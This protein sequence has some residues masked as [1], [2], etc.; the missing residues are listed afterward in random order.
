[1][2]NSISKCDDLINKVVYNIS[3][4]IIGKELEVKNILKGMLAG[5]HVLIEDVPGT[6]KTTLV[7]AIAKSLNLSFSRIQFTPD[8]LPSD[9]TGVSIYNP[10]SMEFEFRKGPVFSN[11]VLADEINRTSPKTQSSLLEVMQERQVTEGNNVY[12]LEEPF[13]IIATENPIEYEGTFSL[14]EAQLDRF[15]MKIH[16]GYVKEDE[17]IKILNIYREN[18]PLMDIKPVANKN[19]VLYLQ[20]SVKKVYVNDEINKYIVDIVN[21][22]R[23][24]KYLFL[25]ASTRAALSL[26]RVAQANALLRGR[27]YV[28]PEDV[29]QNA[30]IVLAHRLIL[31]SLAEANGYSKEEILRQILQTV[32]TPRVNRK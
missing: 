20:Q 1:M 28:I 4:V 18:E 30:V 10:K 5:G 27:D 22:T 24:N 31:N 3:S 9:V 25:G 17:E 8:I 14:P 29:K 13:F 19:D 23:K 16:I 21:A 2:I 6:G 32:S 26:M 15:I 7:K 12:K 11:I